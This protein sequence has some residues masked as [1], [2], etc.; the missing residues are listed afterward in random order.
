[1]FE[2]KVE[3]LCSTILSTDSEFWEVRNKCLNQ[4]IELIMEQADYPD[5]FTADFFRTLKDPV[6]ILVSVKLVDVV[7]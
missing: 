5:V 1:M 2:H 6:K 7:E 4:L 3:Q